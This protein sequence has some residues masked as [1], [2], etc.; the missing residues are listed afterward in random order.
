MFRWMMS[1]Y[2]IKPLVSNRLRKNLNGIFYNQFVWRGCKNLGF[3]SS[4]ICKN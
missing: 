2:V 3:K 1:I 4:E